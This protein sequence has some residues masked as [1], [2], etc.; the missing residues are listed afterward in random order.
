MTKLNLKMMP[1]PP[2]IATMI[3]EYHAKEDSKDILAIIEDALKNGKYFCYKCE[4]PPQKKE[5]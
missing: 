4:W 3:K 1:F 2:R 5:Q